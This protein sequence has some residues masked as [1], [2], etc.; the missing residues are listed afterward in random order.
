MQV[1]TTV[2]LDIAKSHHSGQSDRARV[3]SLLNQQRTLLGLGAD[4]L[5]RMTQR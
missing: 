2:G 5:V 1:V 4:W 3:C